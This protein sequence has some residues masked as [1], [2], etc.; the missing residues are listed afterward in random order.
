MR[1]A[2]SETAS[3]ETAN[4][5]VSAS[6]CRA[7]IPLSPVRP[8]ERSQ[9]VVRQ[10]VNFLAHLIATQ[11]SIPQTRERR[12]EEPKVA[13]SIYAVAAGHV[14]AETSHKLSRDM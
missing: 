2:A 13:A 8:S 9:T 4:A 14:L 7:L 12:R 10:P 11:Q 6:S 1:S 3:S 5:E